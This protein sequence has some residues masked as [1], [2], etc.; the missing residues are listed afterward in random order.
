MDEFKGGFEELMT[1]KEARNFRLLCSEFIKLFPPDEKYKLTDQLIRSSR[2]IEAQIAEGYG[3]Y[4]FQETIQYCR[5]ARGS[6]MESLNHL[7]I[8]N[9]CNYISTAQLEEARTKYDSVLKLINGYISYLKNK[10][11]E[12]K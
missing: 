11:N 10:K 1:W 3:R 9:D 8:A 7:I 6:L 2:G 12:T 4:H 5:Q